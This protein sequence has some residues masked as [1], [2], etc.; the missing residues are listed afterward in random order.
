[1]DDSGQIVA[2]SHDPVP[3]IG[4]GIS[5]LF[6]GNPVHL[7]RMIQRIIGKMAGLGMAGLSIFNP[8][9]SLPLDPND[10]WKN[11]SLKPPKYGFIA[12]K[13][14]KMEVLGGPWYIVGTILRVPSIFSYT[15]KGRP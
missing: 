5:R 14:L 3:P 7:A 12:Q 11:E 10:P 1:M 4:K 8:I 6:Q 9:Y 13:P 2:T 15:P